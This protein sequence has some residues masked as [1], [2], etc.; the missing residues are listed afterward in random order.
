[1]EEEIEKLDEEL[2]HEENIH[3]WEIQIKKLR[4]LR[5]KI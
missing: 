2:D 5:D 1:M 3:R 4:A